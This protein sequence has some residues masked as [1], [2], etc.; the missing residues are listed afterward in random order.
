MTFNYWRRENRR[1]IL[2]SLIYA[3]CQL[4]YENI[5]TKV[6][7]SSQGILIDRWKGKSEGRKV[8][9]LEKEVMID[10]CGEDGLRA[11]LCSCRLHSIY[12][13]NQCCCVSTRKALICSNIAS[14]SSCGPLRWGKLGSS[15]KELLSGRGCRSEISRVSISSVT[16][17]TAAPIL[18]SAIFFVAHIMCR[19]CGLQQESQRKVLD[20]YALLKILSHFRTKA[21]HGHI[22]EV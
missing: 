18:Q 21:L 19:G 11:I 13:Y 5:T 22:Y 20:R 9:E 3:Y 16:P 6:A 14:F 17:T 2:A 10:A 8:A 12:S 1:V 15:I 7:Q 4:I